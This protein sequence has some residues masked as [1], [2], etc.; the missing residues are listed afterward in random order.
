MADIYEELVEATI[1]HLESLKAS[2]RRFIE[3][4]PESL[5]ILGTLKP[6]AARLKQEPAPTETA[7]LNEP[8]ARPASPSALTPAAALSRSVSQESLLESTPDQPAAPPKPV[9]SGPAKAAAFAELRERA[10]KCVKCS[11]LA[12][13]RRN[14]VFGVGNIDA[15][16]MFVG[17]APGAD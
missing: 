3:I 13:S 12:S 10:M 2:G 14:V 9:L 17:E 15:E 1:R 8:M 16:L 5:A 11:H 4:S 7:R 6:P